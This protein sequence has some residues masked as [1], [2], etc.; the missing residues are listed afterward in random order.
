MGVDNLCGGEAKRAKG[1]HK[2][3]LGLGLGPSKV[4]QGGDDGGEDWGAI[5]KGAWWETPKG[6]IVE[7]NQA[8]PT[9][10]KPT[11]LLDERNQAG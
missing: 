3:V 8:L 9:H 4:G 10:L 7:A 1:R 6:H 2:G 5:G 11:I